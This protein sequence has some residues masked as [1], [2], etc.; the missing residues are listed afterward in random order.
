MDTVRHVL[1]IGLDG[2]GGMYLENATSFLPNIK[3]LI[4]HG[5][6]TSALVVQIQH[7]PQRIG[8]PCSQGNQHSNLV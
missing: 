4:D 1:M 5:T 8:Q 2:L 6:S 3:H 7:I